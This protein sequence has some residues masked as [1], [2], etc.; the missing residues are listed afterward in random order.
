[1]VLGEFYKQFV[2]EGFDEN[3]IINKF[4]LRLP[5]NFNFGYDVIDAM[6]ELFPDKKAMYW[7]NE[8]NEKH[9][10]TLDDLRMDLGLEEETE[11]EKEEFHR[12]ALLGW[13]KGYEWKYNN[14]LEMKKHLL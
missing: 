2:E 6:A 12:K 3:G 7:I 9:I 10:F 13:L 11:A 14:F 5:D 8:R 4:E 1:M